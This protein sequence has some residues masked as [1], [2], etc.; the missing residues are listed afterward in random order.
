MYLREFAKHA[1][2]KLLNTL[3][4]GEL[5]SSFSGKH[6]LFGKQY[7]YLKLIGISVTLRIKPKQ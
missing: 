4:V 6:V 7:D 5:S 1:G 3:E 2:E